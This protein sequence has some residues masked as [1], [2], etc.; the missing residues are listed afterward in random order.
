MPLTAD[1]LLRVKD[2][3]TSKLK[4]LGAFIDE[5]LPDYIMVMVANNKT[6]GSMTKDLQLFLGEHTAGFTRWLHE[7]LNNMK[8]TDEVKEIGLVDKTRSGRRKE[9]RSRDS[10]PRSRDHVE[11]RRR[12]RSPLRAHHRDVSTVSSREPHGYTEAPKLHDA[13][14]DISS[15]GS[16]IEERK[17]VSTASLRKE[18]ISSPVNPSESQE[19]GC[20]RSIVSIKDSRPSKPRQNVSRPAAMD[21]VP[22]GLL[23]KKAFNDV[24]TNVE[25][26]EFKGSVFV[27][28]KI[29]HNPIACSDVSSSSPDPASN[30][31]KFYIT[32]SG[33]KTSVTSTVM[34]TECSPDSDRSR[35]RNLEATRV[36]VKSRLGSRNLLPYSRPNTE[37]LSAKDRLGPVAHDNSQLRLKSVSNPHFSMDTESGYEDLDEQVDMVEIVEGELDVDE[38]DQSSGN[39]VDITSNGNDIGHRFV[40]NQ[41]D[42]GVPSKSHLIDRMNQRQLVVNLNETDEDD[43]LSP[44]KVAGSKGIFQKSIRD[45]EQVHIPSSLDRCRYWPNCRNGKECPYIHPSEPCPTFPRCRFGATCIYIHPPCRFDAACTRPDCAFSHSTRSLLPKTGIPQSA[46]TSRVVCRYQSRCN[47][48]SCPFY[49]SAVV[50]AHISGPTA[51]CMVTTPLTTSPVPCRYGSMC[52]N[53]AKCPFFHRDVPRPDQLKWMAPSK[54]DEITD[55]AAVATATTNSGSVLYQIEALK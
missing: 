32:L 44:A 22:S 15:T 17:I 25:L 11:S 46:A 20:I 12:S 16:V 40:I 43:E 13:E 36:S 21:V 37:R 51:R 35:G 6:E 8:E 7:L 24:R 52:M 48:P 42:L 28:R 18:N 10:I 54:R 39:K 3:V 4:C 33:N 5:E 41:E 27:R 23:L 29:V 30:R 14:G 50:S 38:P 53:R 45:T 2:R 55:S 1:F 31:T 9:S 49:H 19:K 47:N 26:P 34:G